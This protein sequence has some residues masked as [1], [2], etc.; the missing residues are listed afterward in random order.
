MK[1]IVLLTLALLLSLSS[2]AQDI[3]GQW[4]GKLSVQGMQLRVVFHIDKKDSSYTATMDSPDQNARGIV[5]SSISFNDS[6][7]RLAVAMAGIEFEGKQITTDSIAGTFKQMGLTFPLNLRRD[8]SATS[9]K[10]IRPQ[11]PHAPFPY[12]T[13]DL[14]FVNQSA[15]ISLAGTLSKPS[16]VGPSPAVVLITGS[17]PQNRD[18]EVFG[19]KPFFVIA[20]YLTRREFAVLRFDD[21]GIGQ[22]EG[23]FANA[24]SY[25]FATDVQA[26]VRFLST[27]PEIDAERIGLVGHSEGAMVASLVA[28]NNPDIAFMVSL[29]GPGIASDLLLLMQREAIGRAS[30]MDSTAL[31]ISL[32]SSERTFKLIKQHENTDSLKVNLRGL[33][34]QL[35]AENPGQ[36]LPQGVTEDQL[37]EQQIASICAPWMLN[38][39]KFDPAR[40]L[41]N[42]SCPILA[43]NGAKDLQVP[44]KAN[45]AAIEKA[46]KS[47]G[48]AS[49]EIL[50]LAGLNHLFQECQTGLPAEY[51]QIEQTFSPSA[52]KIIGDWIEAKT[53]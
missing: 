53:K 9:T 37:I 12:Q 21:R 50:E 3:T 17:G 44:A 38:F 2:Q 48:N 43:L 8:N 23:D 25:D 20:D 7:L 16:G 19:H 49:I 28:N 42:V 14:K 36:H 24:T 10:P 35:I 39:I 22:S 51:G 6:N 1:S 29:A 47:G 52:L 30:G 27:H 4:H 15:G 13:D 45:L 40:V 41:E 11:E 46:A 5:V 32:D 18:E 34:K 31:Q 26:A 33:F